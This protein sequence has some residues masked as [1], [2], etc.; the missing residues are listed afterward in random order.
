MADGH[1]AVWLSIAGHFAQ[2]M[3]RAQGAR[4][5]IHLTTL[6]EEAIAGT[7]YVITQ[8]CGGGWKPA[9]ALSWPTAPPPSL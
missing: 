7:Q 1:R 6:L 4:C 5:E 2:G 3:A 8:L 9:G